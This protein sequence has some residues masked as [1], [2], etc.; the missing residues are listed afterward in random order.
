LYRIYHD[1]LQ[2]VPVHFPLGVNN[3]II[4]IDPR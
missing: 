2:V 4:H 3:I 1:W